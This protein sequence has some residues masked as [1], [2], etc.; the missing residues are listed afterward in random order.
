[1]SNR[2]DFLK[3]VAGGAAF[4]GL[5][6]DP[7]EVLAKHDIEKITI[8]HTN[9]VHSHIDPF[10]AN[11][12]KWAG[13]GGVA[14]R[15]ALIRKIRAEEKNVL[16]LD[17]GDIFQ[18]TPYFNIYGGEIELKMMS[19]MGYDAST[20]GNHDFDHGMEELVKQLP[21]A[22]FPL[23]CSN[24]DFT[25][26]VMNQKTIPSK[27]FTKGGIKIG[28]FGVGIELR[29]LVD[30]KLYGN[31]KYLD[32]LQKAAFQAHYLRE[33]MKCDIV[34]CLSHLG[35]KYKEEKVS[36]EILAKQSL[37]IDLILG[38]HTHTFLDNPVR[39][40]NRHDKEVLVAQ[41]GWAG[42]K[43]GR[44]DFYV[45]KNSGRTE[46]IGSTVKVSEKSIA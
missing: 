10:P 7:I 46:A 4:L 18:G 45:E 33:E 35:Y 29:G 2:R 9:D 14:K 42:I 19:Q 15:A 6:W 31:T 5:S 11:D 39:Y 34:I 26:T 30:P 25:D 8:L 1:M 37:N 43:L 16:L 13:L 22:S 44:I 17:V 28:V 3:T 21:N 32:P 38:G 41:V 27:I 24:Y 40:R 36:D 12:P 23:L 20:I